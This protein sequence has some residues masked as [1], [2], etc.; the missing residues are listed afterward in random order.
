M[1]VDWEHDYPSLFDSIIHYLYKLSRMPQEREM[2]FL[3]NLKT[4]KV[5][6][7]QMERILGKKKSEDMCL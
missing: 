4:V 3:Y 5:V 2:L 1:Q 6:L 7:I